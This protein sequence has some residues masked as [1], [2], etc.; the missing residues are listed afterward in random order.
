MAEISDI[1]V[2]QKLTEL[3]DELDQMAAEGASLVGGVA[4]E[5]AAKTVR[6]MAGAVYQH[7]MA[8]RDGPKDS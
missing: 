2:Y 3:A 8:D 4:L 6:G 5:T 7:I 1:A